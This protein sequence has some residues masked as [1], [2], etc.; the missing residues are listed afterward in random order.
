M[1]EIGTKRGLR[2]GRGSRPKGRFPRSGVDYAER[3]A[4]CVRDLFEDLGFVVWSGM[5]Y[6]THDGAEYL[7]TLCGRPVMPLNE[8]PAFFHPE[9]RSLIDSTLEQAWLELRKDNPNDEVMA[10]R[11]LAT[12]IVALAAIGETDP[13]KLKRFALNAT[14]AAGLGVKPAVQKT[15]Q[16]GALAP[17]I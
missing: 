3:C 4:M 7:C 2:K 5:S 8:I 12:T 11:K 9:I 14:R 13:A 17:S 6:S 1:S 10:R 15:A 16:K